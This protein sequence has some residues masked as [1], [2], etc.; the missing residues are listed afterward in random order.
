MYTNTITQCHHHWWMW[1]LMVC[2]D[3]CT[4]VNAWTS[5]PFEINKP[6]YEDFSGFL[7]L[8]HVCELFG[9]LKIRYVGQYL[10]FLLDTF[11]RCS[12]F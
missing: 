1:M 12:Y 7:H 9:D 6:L 5:A 3:I 11:V 10:F 4:L 8:G 2:G